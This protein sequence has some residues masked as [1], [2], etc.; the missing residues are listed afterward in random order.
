MLSA[1]YVQNI[2]KKD[3][4]L[5]ISLS[6]FEENYVEVFFFLNS[7]KQKERDIHG[8]ISIHIEIIH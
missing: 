5:G 1:N 8:H 2:L 3:G 6:S 7:C 4:L